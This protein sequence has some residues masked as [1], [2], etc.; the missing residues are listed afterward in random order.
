MDNK[1]EI[2]GVV[3]FNGYIPDEILLGATIRSFWGLPGYRQK[4]ASMAAFMLNSQSPENIE[5]LMKFTLQQALD[6]VKKNGS[7]RIQDS[8]I[9]LEQTAQMGVGSVVLHCEING[10]PEDEPD[11]LEKHLG[12]M[13]SVYMGSVIYFGAVSPVEP[14]RSK[15][16]IER[17]VLRR[18]LKGI[19]IRP[20]RH[21]TPASDESWFPIYD[22]CQQL[23]IPVYVESGLNYWADCPMDVG[24]PSHVDKIAGRYPKLKFIIGHCGWP[25]TNDAVAAALRHPNVFIDISGYRP[26]EM[27]RLGSGFEMLF[28]YGNGALAHKVLFGSQW[29]WICKN[30]KDVVEEFQKMPIL[31]G[32]KENWLSLN[33]KELLNLA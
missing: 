31:A 15:L 33:A 25:W 3:D 20:F 13:A 18:N 2:T 27:S 14:E 11:Q 28:Q 7:K 17:G 21:I 8:N 16:Y 22:I 32:V 26:G 6:L 5:K 23:N 30:L 19:T 29:N 9:W 4:A 12:N 1:S 24:H 10:N